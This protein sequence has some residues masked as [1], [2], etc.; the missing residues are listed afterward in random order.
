MS[1]EKDDSEKQLNNPEDMEWINGE[2]SNY[3]DKKEYED[4]VVLI[5]SVIANDSE[6]LP[7]W[8][9]L[10]LLM[11]MQLC[12]MTIDALR[13]N[14][15]KFYKSHTHLDDYLDKV[16]KFTPKLHCFYIDPLARE[17]DKSI[18]IS[19]PKDSYLLGEGPYNEEESKNKWSRI[20]AVEDNIKE[21]LKMIIMEARTISP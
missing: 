2:L 13:V 12:E 11:N 19:G 21:V 9:L 10:N 7:K 18:H 6:A 17:F 14:A 20:K 16:V 5:K 3:L 8:N 4:Y 1:E 15:T